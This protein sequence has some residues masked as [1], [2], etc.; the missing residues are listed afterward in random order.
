LSVAFHAEP[1]I[2]KWSW[3]EGDD[4]LSVACR[5]DGAE[6]LPTSGLQPQLVV[7]DAE[8]EGAVFLH[9][10]GDEGAVEWVLEVL[11]EE[12][13]Q[14]ARNVHGVVA[15]AVRPGS[16]TPAITIGRGD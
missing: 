10:P 11:L 13:L 2:G 14:G 1:T 8:G 12:T 6:R 15:F 4:T 5:T 7:F 9:G 16:T 3:T